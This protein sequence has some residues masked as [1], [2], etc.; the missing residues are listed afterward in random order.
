MNVQLGGDQVIKKWLW[1]TLIILFFIIVVVGCSNSN[2]DD[3]SNDTPVEDESLE[4]SG[5]EESI[6][7]SEE[8]DT[9]S[10]GEDD[11]I[12][13]SD[14]EVNDDASNDNRTTS[15]KD[16][17]EDMEVNERVKHPNGVVATLE[18]IS[19]EED[20]IAVDFMIQNG[21]G[22]YVKLSLDGVSLI[23]DTGFE[24]SFQP[25]DLRVEENERMEGTLIFIGRLDDEATSLTFS[26]N[27]EAD[28]D[29]EEYDGEQYPKIVFKDIKIER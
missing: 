8:A 29:A 6:E 2:N 13:D 19:F 4:E 12:T 1:N 25:V 9:V 14:E 27:E 3:T 22:Y 21:F 15:N 24:Y 5:E 23:D 18:T 16:L 20:Y 17:P 28:S 26:F 11:E 7:E 10:T